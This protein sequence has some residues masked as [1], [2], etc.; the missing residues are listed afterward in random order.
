MNLTPTPIKLVLALLI[1]V[2]VA[3]TLLAT[4]PAPDVLRSSRGAATTSGTSSSAENSTASSVATTS[5]P[6]ISSSLAPSEN[7]TTVFLSNGDEEIVNLTY[8]DIANQPEQMDVYLPAGVTTGGNGSETTTASSSPVDPAVLYINGGAWMISSK[9]V[10]WLDMFTLLTGEGYVVAS[11]NYAMPPPSPSFPANI[12]DVACGV[13][14]LRFEAAWLHI[15]PAH[16]GLLGDSSG[17]N[18][19]ALEALSSAAANGTFDQVGQYTQYSSRV[20]AVVDAFGPA[21]LT[22]PS[23]LGTTINSQIRLRGENLTQYVFGGTMTN[24]ARASPV[25]YVNTSIGAPPFL[26]LHGLNDTIVPTIQSIQL[27]DALTRQG[28][29][30]V[31]VLVQNCDHE[32]R[33]FSP[34]RPISPSIPELQQDILNFYGAQLKGS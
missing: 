31:L 26:I 22:D 29:R 17:G 20:Q 2:L 4:L 15:D 8:C 25:D 1:V 7:A 24:L 33:Q 19:A 9:S 28:D 11:I 23:F 10:N 16:I 3:G 34:G 12:E 13:R 18:L 5:S 30:A 21:N 14:F 27:Y 32:F 6:N